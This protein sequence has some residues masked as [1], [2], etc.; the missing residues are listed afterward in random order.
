MPVASPAVALHDPLDERVNIQPLWGFFLTLGLVS[1]VLGVLA[2][3]MAFIVGM[4][5]VIVLGI[6]LLVAGIAEVVYVVIGRN[7]RGFAL[8]LLA[9][10]LYLLIGLFILEDPARAGVVLTLLLAAYFFVGGVLRIIFSLAVQFPAWPWVLVNGL[11]ELIL[12][13][14]I[15]AVWPDASLKVLGLLIGID[16]LFHGWSSIDL[17]LRARKYSP[18]ESA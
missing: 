18:V 15:L 16:L 14:I 7:S 3:S 13:L 17:A 1:V 5:S 2:I 10:A 11:V 8:H 12:G 9:A 6:L 4:A